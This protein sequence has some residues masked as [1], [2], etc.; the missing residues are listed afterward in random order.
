MYLDQN[1]TRK[2]SVFANGEC[3][4]PSAIRQTAAGFTLT[5][6]LVV[7]AIIAIL[8]AIGIPA[9]I[10]A[11]NK[12]KQ[13]AITMELQQIGTALENFK[14]D[15]EAYPPNCMNDGVTTVAVNDVVRMFRKAFPRS[16]EPIELIEALAGGAGGGPYNVTPPTLGNGLTG[17][18]AV[19]FWL[20]GFSADPQYPISGPGGP[21]FSE[22]PNDSD[23]AL[24][25]DDEI[26]E[27][28]SRRYEF[29]LTRLIPRNSNGGFDDTKGR[30]IEYDDP[31]NPAVR[32]RINLWEYAPSG[33]Q[34]AIVYFDTSR[35]DPDTYDLSIA[36]FA[37][38]APQLFAVKKLRE[39]IS[40]S[41][42]NSDV[43]FVNNG[44]FQVLHA[45]LDDV[46]G[47]QFSL[48][49][50]DIPNNGNNAHNSV[51]FYPTGPFVGDI[52]DTVGNF[53]TG[54]LE[55]AQE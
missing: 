23:T 32:R 10:N 40:T 3:G 37:P 24:N 22:N 15:F 27:D 45:G 50:L 30:F 4:R 11:V 54:T 48:F 6:L 17:S 14:T 7:I 46:W 21:S 13:A 28:R 34:Q 26:L 49:Q 25:G 38:T 44:K 41:S 19:Y 36:G 53:M 33:S 20:G 16:D 35:H 29:D 9:A 5:E 52:A 2:Q 55:D 12:S 43:Q 1:E 42:S 39:G 51:L 8:S 47:D 18:E 31:S